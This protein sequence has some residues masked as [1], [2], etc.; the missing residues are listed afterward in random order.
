MIH[1]HFSQGQQTTE[2]D[3]I[4]TAVTDVATHSVPDAVRPHGSSGYYRPICT[5]T[6]A[7]VSVLSHV[8]LTALTL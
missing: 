2:G 4:T 6:V 5:E 1:M 3:V 8:L 7:F